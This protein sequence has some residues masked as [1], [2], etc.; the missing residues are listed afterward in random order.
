L[1]N[2]ILRSRGL[3]A[4][5]PDEIFF[6][7]IEWNRHLYAWTIPTLHTLLKVNGFICIEQKII[8]DDL[9]SKIFPPFGSV[10][11]MKVRKIKASDNTII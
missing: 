9:V 4:K 3:P 11:I 10:I 6:D 2:L 1:R 7:N 5:V 8:S